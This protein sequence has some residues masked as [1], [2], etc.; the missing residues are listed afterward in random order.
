MI[1]GHPCHVISFTFGAVPSDIKNCLVERYWIDLQRGAHALRREQSENGKLMSRT[2]VELKQFNAS[3]RSGRKI[4][5]P[6]HGIGEGY[7]FG[8]SK[9]TTY[10]ADP[11][12]VTDTWLLPDS[13]KFPADLPNSRFSVKYK[14]GTP[15][16]DSL[17]QAAYQFGQD[18][19][20]PAK[21][22]IEA[23]KRL[24]EHLAE[25]D[26]QKDELKA[27]SAARGGAGWAGWLPWAT[28]IGA[29]ATLLVVLIRRGLGG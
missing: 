28:A 22:P 16:T 18:R 29:V 17:R 15:I 7:L 1:D 10:E 23:Q 14:P 4:W 13:L 19:R 26:A 11:T 20:P 24:E 27:S 6:Y 21:T 8:D 2:T 12:Q 25:A 5:L 9:K 3:D